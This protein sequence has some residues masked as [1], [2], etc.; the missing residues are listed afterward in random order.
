DPPLEDPPPVDPPSLDSPPEEP[1]PVDSPDDSPPSEP[2][3]PELLSR[4]EIP[5]AA[6]I[7]PTTPTLYEGGQKA[8]AGAYY[9]AS[10]ITRY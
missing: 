9:E 1:F 2:S 7:E 8:Q 6:V 3:E 5:E 4:V 10:R